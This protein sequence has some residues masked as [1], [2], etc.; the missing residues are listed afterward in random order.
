MIK[1]DQYIKQFKKSLNRDIKYELKLLK[2]KRRENNKLKKM[3]KKLG[4]EQKEHKEVE[5]LLTVRKTLGKACI[6]TLKKSREL[7]CLLKKEI[8]VLAGKI[9][10]LFKKLYSEF[11]KL[12]PGIQKGAKITLKWLKRRAIDLFKILFLKKYSVVALGCFVFLFLNI[13]ITKVNPE[14]FIEMTERV[15][16]AKGWYV[17]I[18]GMKIG[19]LDRKNTFYDIKDELD[20]EYAWFKDDREIEELVTFEANTKDLIKPSRI[21]FTNNLTELC[22]NYNKAWSICVENEKIVTLKSKWQAEHILDKIIS[23]FTPAEDEDEKI[24]NVTLDF[25]ENTEIRLTFSKKEDIYSADEAFNYLL[26]GTTEDKIYEIVQG[27]TVWDIAAR[28]DIPLEDIQKANP[29]KNLSSVYIGDKLNLTVPKP[30]L[31]ININYTHTYNEK[32]PYTTR[33]IRDDT[34]YRTEYVLVQSGIYGEKEVSAL[35]VFRNNEKID[36]E[37]LNET[38]LSYPRIKIV[39]IGTLRTPDDV[40][41]SSY[42]LPPDTGIITSKFGPRNGTLHTGIDL[43]IKVG[44]PILAYSSGTVIFTGRKSGYGK[45]VIIQHANNIVTYYAHLSEIQ[46]SPGDYVARKQQIALSG[47]T[48]Y[49]TGPH[50]HFEIRLNGKPTDPLEYV[51]QPVY[52]AGNTTKQTEVTNDSDLGTEEFGIGPMGQ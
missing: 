50:I 8:P 13:N 30:Y 26:K 25:A 33:V 1:I 12:F 34:L 28:F 10:D 19:L 14:T 45:L 39:R 15:T 41:M 36:A 31:N 42:I 21:K 17:Y 43:A 3:K 29:D 2:S 27:D 9:T 4:S 22:K 35:E 7:F 49:S 47:N 20:D 44:T 5:I 24:E 46:V 37:I 51:K 40:L 16:E 38:I 48:G 11:K 32:I 23:F 52:S 18:D 6:F